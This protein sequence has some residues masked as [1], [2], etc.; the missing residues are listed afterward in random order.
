MSDNCL[1]IIGGAPFI[2][3]KGKMSSQQQALKQNELDMNFQHMSKD[4]ILG[5]KAH[6][7]EDLHK[8]SQ[9]HEQLIGIILSEE[10][11]VIGLHR[12]H[13]DDMVELVKQV[14]NLPTSRILSFFL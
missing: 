10:E 12:Q 13:I 14:S 2:A 7:E 9:K 3:S 4:D 6:S 8:M 11:E 1:N 5:W